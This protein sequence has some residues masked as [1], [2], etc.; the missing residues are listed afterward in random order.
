MT[1]KATVHYLPANTAG[2]DFIV[3]DLHGCYD[4]LM[5]ALQAANFD[6]NRDRVI[7]VGD[8]IDR[9]PQSEECIG[10]LYEPWFHAIRG[11][12]EQLMIDAVN[13]AYENAG[14]NWI[15]NGGMWGL[16]LSGS[17]RREYAR[18]LDELPYALVVG[19]GRSRY[20]VVHAE[21]FGRDCDLDA[22]AN[23]GLD[24]VQQ[25]SML[26][27][28]E[29]CKKGAFGPNQEQAGLSTTYCGH[30][31]VDAP[32]R[33]GSHVF[34]DTGAFMPHLKP[35]RQGHLTLLEHGRNRELSF[36]PRETETSLS[37]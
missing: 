14:I 19:K 15:R 1:T 28:R 25:D 35:G 3:G 24:E 13:D 22:A 36:P 17:M 34:L 5:A 29:I 18:R 33:R 6:A 23:T 32:F 4:E 2:R 16:N 21:F 10:L 31:I 11:N 20:N 37:F 26:W 27:G 8:L 30:T 7:S 12:H 9:G